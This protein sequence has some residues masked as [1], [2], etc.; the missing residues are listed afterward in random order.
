MFVER[1]ELLKNKYVHVYIHT[2]TADD[3]KKHGKEF[4]KK[5]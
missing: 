2:L 1:I 3:F 4:K 5:Q